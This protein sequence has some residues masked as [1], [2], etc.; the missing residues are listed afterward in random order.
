MPV[1]STENYETKQNN[2][3]KIGN[4]NYSIIG[5]GFIMP[6]HTEAIYYT[7]G[8]IIDVVNTAHGQNTWKKIKMEN[9]M[10]NLMKI[11]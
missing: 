4:M 1:N 9:T 8:K 7:K 3:L 11:K 6:R 10:E 2:K 5:T